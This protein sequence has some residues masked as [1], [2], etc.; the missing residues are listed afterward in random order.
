MFY[1]QYTEGSDFHLWK[2][3]L[4]Q[5]LHLSARASPIAHYYSLYGPSPKKWDR[6]L[7]A[8]LQPTAEKG[9]A[10]LKESDLWGNALQPVAL[11]IA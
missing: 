9:N 11:Q 10:V 2:G 5:H 6:Q 3:L 4:E 1:N 7:P 8:G